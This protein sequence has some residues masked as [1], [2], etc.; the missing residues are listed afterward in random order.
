[1]IESCDHR[2]SKYLDAK[3]LNI[4]LNVDGRGGV[5]AELAG[6]VRLILFAKGD[7]GR[8]V[9]RRTSYIRDRR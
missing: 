3:I 4:E 9:I 6:V 1:M 2:T 7:R 5:G 8:A